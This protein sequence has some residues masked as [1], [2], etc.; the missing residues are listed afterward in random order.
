MGDRLPNAGNC[1]HGSCPTIYVF[2]WP[3]QYHDMPAPLLNYREPVLMQ[4][5]QQTS[6]SPAIHD[7]EPATTPR[8]L[9]LKP[10]VLRPLLVGTAVAGLLGYLM[11][12]Q[13]GGGSPAIAAEHQG[14]TPAVIELFTSQ[15][16]YSCPPAEALFGDLV[17][18]N[19]LENLVALEFHVD[20][21]DS[22][23]YGSH[24][25]HKDPFSSPDNSLRQRLYNRADLRGRRG[26]YTPQ[27]VVNGQ[28]AAVGSKRRTVLESIRQLKRPVVKIDVAEQPQSDAAAAGLH[29]EL[30]GD[31]SGVPDDTHVWLAV[32]DIKETTKI[33]T[34]ENHDK[35]LTS[36]HMV[37]Q[38]ELL[39]PQGGYTELKGSDGALQLETGIVL[40]EGQGCAILLQGS[41]PG[42][43]HGA[44]YCPKSLWKP[45]SA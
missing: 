36:H 25:S 1:Y 22:L 33:T 4:H 37:R 26:V 42:P 34:G 31:F 6:K 11:L 43:V 14:E 7:A 13:F 5:H 45:K 27:V 8:P 15:G 18:A 30:S 44:S 19:D 41:E 24:G 29:I 23:V 21:W 16:C 20:Y 35:A 28:Y 17:E 12:E 32:F 39:S 40:G 3:R 2:R 38:M 10:S 9:L